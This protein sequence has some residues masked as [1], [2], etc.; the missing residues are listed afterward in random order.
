MLKTAILIENNY[1]ELEA[2]YPYYRLKEAGFQPVFAGPDKDKIYKSK[3]GYP[4]KSEISFELLTPEEY[5]GVIIPGGY[6]PDIIRRDKKALSFVKN[7]YNSGKL[8]A[9]ICH[10]GWVLISAGI[11]KGKKITGFFSIKDDL[12]NSGAEYLDK[13][14]VVDKNLVTSRTPDDLPDFCKAILN[15]MEKEQ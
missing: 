2:W 6:A 8:T 7:I 11:L 3:N 9:A 14:V 1:Q 13:S 5:S 4:L 15:I 10:G 12:I